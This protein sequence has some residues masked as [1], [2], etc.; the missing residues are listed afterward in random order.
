MKSVLYITT[1]AALLS[2]AATSA[3]AQQSS[4]STPWAGL[5]YGVFAGKTNKVD[6]RSRDQLLFDAGLGGSHHYRLVDGA[7]ND[8]FSP[9]S[10]NGMARG[11]TPA[12]GC[13]S[14]SGTEEWGLRLGY[15][16]QVGSLVYGV[17]AEYM[18][19]G[20]EDSTS[21]FSTE[22]NSYTMTREL[23]RALSLRAR[24]GFA[25]GAN[26]ENLLYA[27][28]GKSRAKISNTFT[29][30]NTVNTFSDSGPLDRNGYSYGFGYERLMGNNLALGLE[31]VYMKFRDDRYRAYASGAPGSSLLSSQNPAGAVGMR[32]SD[33]NM[34]FDTWRATLSYRFNQN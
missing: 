11:A 7:G 9:G 33:R 34:S 24:L 26:S 21:S 17:L 20:L 22:P 15:D 13:K 2:L 18:R 6:N 32:R 30:T 3:M 28:G 4:D 14:D 16:R 23:E 8:A 19:A 12:A 29:T 31:Y 1:S 27:S 5:H 10:C 25:F